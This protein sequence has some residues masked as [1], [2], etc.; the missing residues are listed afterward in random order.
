MATPL[1]YSFGESFVPTDNVAGL[2]KFK[3]SL[4]ESLN[5]TDEFVVGFVAHSFSIGNKGP[6]YS[7]GVIGP[8]GYRK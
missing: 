1:S 6:F 2:Y 4:S 5:M 8:S 7:V 3:A